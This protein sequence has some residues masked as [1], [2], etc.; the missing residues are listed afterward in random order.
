[1]EMGLEVWTGRVACT[2][3]LARPVLV[4]LGSGINIFQTGRARRIRAEISPGQ[5]HRSAR[6]FTQDGQFHWKRLGRE[7]VK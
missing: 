7:I 5:F 3:G 2:P 4:G 1:M 6:F